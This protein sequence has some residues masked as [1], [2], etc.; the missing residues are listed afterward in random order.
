MNKQLKI[1]VLVGAALFAAGCAHTGRKFSSEHVGDIE[2]GVQSK[3]EI[4]AWFGKPLQT[5]MLTDSPAGCVER[6]NYRAGYVSAVTNMVK[7]LLV[8][9]DASGKVCDHGYSEVK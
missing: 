6:W 4:K 3:K 1:T 5:T 2:N 8:D 9:F 7:V